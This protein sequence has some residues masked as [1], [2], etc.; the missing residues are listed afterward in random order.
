MAIRSLLALLVLFLSSRFIEAIGDEC[1][2]DDSKLT[3]NTAN[4]PIAN[5]FTSG[6]AVGE[7]EALKKKLEKGLDKPDGFTAGDKDKLVNTYKDLYE[8]KTAAFILKAKELCVKEVEGK[9]VL[10]EEKYKPIE[11]YINGPGYLKKEALVTVLNKLKDWMNKFEPGLGDRTEGK[12]NGTMVVH[13][14]TAVLDKNSLGIY[15]AKAAEELFRGLKHLKSKRDKRRKKRKSKKAAGTHKA[16]RHGVRKRSRGGQ[17]GQKSRNRRANLR[18]KARG[19]KPRNHQK[20]R[21]RNQKR[22]YRV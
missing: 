20:R 4:D 6:G 22:G 8:T 15:G 1:L 14:P 16:R 7:E 5:V 9:N 11:E 21:T 19:I 18:N 17:R 12:L 13:T 2:K 10:D 3:I